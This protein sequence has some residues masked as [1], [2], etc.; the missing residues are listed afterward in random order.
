MTI[1]KFLLRLG[2]MLAAVI[3]FAYSGLPVG[4]KALC[5]AM[6]LCGYLSNPEYN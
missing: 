5:I 6:V 2:I 1:V 3:A 4:L